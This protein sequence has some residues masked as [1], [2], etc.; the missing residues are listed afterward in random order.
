MKK[1]TAIQEFIKDLKPTINNTYDFNHKIG[2]EVAIS[3]ATKLLE[4]EKKQ[5]V[6]AFLRTDKEDILMYHEK[7]N[8]PLYQSAIEFYNQT[9]NKK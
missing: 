4:L 9:F 3:R 2:F 6:G 5:I 8:T 1:N 7:E